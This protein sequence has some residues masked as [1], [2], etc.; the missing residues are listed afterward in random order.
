[1]TFHLPNETWSYLAVLPQLGRL[2]R[3]RRTRW[4]GWRRRNG[5]LCLRWLFFTKRKEREKFKCSTR[6]FS[7]DPWPLFG[8]VNYCAIINVE[9]NVQSSNFE[10]ETLSCISHPRLKLGFWNEKKSLERE[11]IFGYTVFGHSWLGDLP[12]CQVQLR[13]HNI[14]VMTVMFLV[15]HTMCPIC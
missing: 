2:H 3:L 12:W 10:I 5:Y 1:M 14:A 15:N 7:N 6:I 8:Q 4:K 11:R 9:N 13:R